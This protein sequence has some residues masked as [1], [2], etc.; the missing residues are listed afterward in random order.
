MGFIFIYPDFAKAFDLV[1]QQRL[2]WKLSMYGVEG[3]VRNWIG[4][5]L[6]GHRQRLR[7]NGQECS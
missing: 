2:L 3:E 6:N 5:F 4:Q 7:V 1:P